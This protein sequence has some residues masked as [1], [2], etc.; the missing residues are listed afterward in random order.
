MEPRTYAFPSV[1]AEFHL[2]NVQQ[3]SAHERKKRK[4]II[5]LVLISINHVLLSLT[6][7]FVG[8]LIRMAADS[9]SDEPE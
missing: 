5:K 2:H 1:V 7:I 9:S 8:N 4:K 6:G 3:L